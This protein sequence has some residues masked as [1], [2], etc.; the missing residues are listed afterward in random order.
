MKVSAARR[1]TMKV[2][3][4]VEERGTYVH[5]ALR[6]ELDRAK[7]SPRDAGFVT[8]AVLGVLTWQR[9]LDTWIGNLSSVPLSRL[10]RAVQRNLRFALFQLRFMERVPDYAVLSDA[11]EMAKQQSPK[12]AG[13]INAVLRRAHEE[14]GY[15]TPLLDSEDP[16]AGESVAV[17]LSFPDWMARLVQEAIPGADGRRALWALNQPIVTTVRVNALRTTRAALLSELQREGTPAEASPVS[18]VGIRLVG[19]IDP[20]QLS[21]YQKGDCTIQGESSMLIAPLLGDM[22]GKRVLDAC[23]APGGKTTHLVEVNDGKA[24]VVAYDLYP[25]RADAIRAQVRRLQLADVVVQARDARQ[26]T[27]EF[28]GVLLDAPCS[29]LG[30]IARKPDLKWTMTADKLKDIVSVQ[31]DL[32]DA[33]SEHVAPGGIFLYTTCTLTVQENEQQI[34]AFLDRHPDFHLT[35]FPDIEET[36]KIRIDAVGLARIL[37]QDFFSDG[38]FIARMQRDI[39]R[40][41]ETQ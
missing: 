14:T 12:A 4:G 29:G 18:A 16:S 5:L 38:F 27:G 8:M 17:R 39:R 13:F 7:L 15:M 19:R 22:R 33:L 9:L 3:Q 1:C 24:Q 25:K 28:D 26:A 6:Q 11:V 31:R 32:L 2:L 36:A 35:A 23:A 37:P 34:K 41:E 40:Q 30:A 20:V 10:E 21:A